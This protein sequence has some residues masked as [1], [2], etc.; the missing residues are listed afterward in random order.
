MFV[1]FSGPQDGD[2]AARTSFQQVLSDAHMR[3]VELIRNH[4]DELQRLQQ[5]DF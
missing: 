3:H 1:E 4:Y 2:F 5:R